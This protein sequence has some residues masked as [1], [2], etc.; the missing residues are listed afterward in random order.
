M[1][2]KPSARAACS[3]SRTTPSTS[4]WRFPSPSVRTSRTLGRTRRRKL[5]DEHRQCARRRGRNSSVGDDVG[6]VRGV[7]SQCL[8]ERLIGPDALLVGAAAEHHATAGMHASCESG[9]EP[10]LADARL[11]GHDHE[12]VIGGQIALPALPQPPQGCRAADEGRL[13]DALEQRGHR[14]RA[15]LRRGVGRRAGEAAGTWIGLCLG[16]SGLAAEAE[17]RIVRGRTASSF[18][19]HLCRLT[20]NIEDRPSP[21]QPGVGSMTS[22]KPI[23][24][25]L[26]EP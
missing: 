6:T 25:G 16:A 3:S 7:V 8:N 4:W 20:R 11:A 12:T 14:H 17:D 21:G 24:M 1:S 10:C 26:S 23:P 13:L 9:H 19:C 18:R 5:G 15:E 2:N 22:R